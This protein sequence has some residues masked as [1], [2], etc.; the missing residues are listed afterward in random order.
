MNALLIAAVFLVV[1]LVIWLAVESLPGRGG[2]RGERR[3][4]R[5]RKSGSEDFEAGHV[6]LLIAARNICA[7]FTDMSGSQ[8]FS[9]PPGNHA[10]ATKA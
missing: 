10:S 3:E 1:L 9:F 8:A 7:P 6:F 4:P 5:E 2:C